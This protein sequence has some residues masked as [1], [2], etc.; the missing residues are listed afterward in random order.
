M[1]N[2]LERIAVSSHGYYP[3]ICL[4][5]LKETMKNLVM[6]AGLWPKIWNWELSYKRHEC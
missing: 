4:E 5:G 6:I 2:E 1:I 3:S